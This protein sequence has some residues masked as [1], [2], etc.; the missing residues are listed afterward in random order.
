MTV[1]SSSRW[2]V[3]ARTATLGALCLSM[4]AC[5]SGGSTT[6]STKAGAP[7][8]SY[9]V[10]TASVG[11]VGTILVDGTGLT[12]Y[13]FE[14][15]H[16]S[17]PTCTGSCSAAWPPYLLPAGVTTPTAGPGVKASLL[18]TVRR[19]DGTLQVT[20]D[21]WPLYRWVGDTRTGVDTGQGLDQFGGFW[22]VVSPSG[23]AITR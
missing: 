15:D 5:S 8:A 6:S 3:A 22:Y 23:T 1:S 2:P 17:N 16:Q 4:A 21:R 13:L 12:L 18:G 7:A 10:K 20:Y 19:S 9:E 11:G 14:A